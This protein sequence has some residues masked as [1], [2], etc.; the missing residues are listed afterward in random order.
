MMN[1]KGLK[2]SPFSIFNNKYGGMNNELQGNEKYYRA[3]GKRELRG[4]YKGSYQF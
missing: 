2:S 1:D 4:L 3:D